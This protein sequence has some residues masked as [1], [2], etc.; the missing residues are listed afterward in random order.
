MIHYTTKNK[1]ALITSKLFIHSRDP[2]DSFEREVLNIW[3]NNS[4]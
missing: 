4:V 1:S 2:E 3:K